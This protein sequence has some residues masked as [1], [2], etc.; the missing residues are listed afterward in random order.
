MESETRTIKRVC[1]E[2]LHLK[3][4]RRWMWQREM[5][6]GGE[7]TVNCRE[8]MVDVVERREKAERRKEAES[9]REKTVSSREKKRGFRKE[10][11]VKRF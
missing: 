1:F 11:G 3:R 7:K 9:S 2:K 8:K 10:E 5:V 4:S 6:S